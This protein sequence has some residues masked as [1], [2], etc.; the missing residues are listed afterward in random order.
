MQMDATLLGLRIHLLTMLFY[1]QL[2]SLNH[3]V[4]RQEAQALPKPRAGES[5]SLRNMLHAG[6]LARCP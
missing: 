6:V 1:G 2:R 4:L 3:A 5:F